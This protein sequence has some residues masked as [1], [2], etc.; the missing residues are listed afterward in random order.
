[1]PGFFDADFGSPIPWMAQTEPETWSG[2][3]INLASLEAVEADV[4]FGK[5]G[6]IMEATA[7]M[8]DIHS[9]SGD[10]MAE[11]GEHTIPFWACSALQTIISEAELKIGK[12]AYWITMRYKRTVIMKT[13]LGVPAE[14]SV[15]HFILEDE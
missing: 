11:N 7:E 2:F 4:P 1:M 3:K 14:N 10:E 8:K 9:Q 12:K 13:K 15:A 5:T 6:K